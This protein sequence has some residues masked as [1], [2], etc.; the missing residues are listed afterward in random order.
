MP[1]CFSNSP[2]D[3]PESVKRPGPV[4]DLFNMH[5]FSRS[6]NI[7]SKPVMAKNG[8]RATSWGYL[9]ASKFP[10][11]A[12]Q[13][14]LRPPKDRPRA[15]KSGPRDA[16]SSPRVAQE[17]SRAPQERPKSSQE[18]PR[19]AQ[20]RPRAPQDVPRHATAPQKASR[21]IVFDFSY[22]KPVPSAPRIRQDLMP[23]NLP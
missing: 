20:E 14:G 22:G 9:R 11:R 5:S 21:A 10:V 17:W 2:V 4:R 16:K 23:R 12:T 19:S 6:E 15:A 18:L 8:K 7:A 3:R 1:P 13:S